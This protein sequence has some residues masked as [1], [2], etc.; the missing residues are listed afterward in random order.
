MKYILIILTLS[1]TT[2]SCKAQ[3]PII[4]L[5]DNDDGIT[6]M[7]MPE[8]GYYKDVNNVLNGF[9]GTWL[10]TNGNTSLK[11]TLVKSVQYFNGK[12]YEDVIIGGY[13]YIENGVEKINTISNIDINNKFYAKIWGNNVYDNCSIIPAD[14]CIEGEKRLSLAILDPVTEQHSGDL[15]LH[16]RTVNGQEALKA[17][18]DI[19]YVGNNYLDTPTP[20]PTMPNQMRNIILIKQ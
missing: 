19:G 17:M 7:D 15:L 14:D 11:V 20:L 5:A 9:E 6:Q 2:Y 10:Y 1:I 4:N 8:N 16:K 3:S 13:Q 18:I 12:F